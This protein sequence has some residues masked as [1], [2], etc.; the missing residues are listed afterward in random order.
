VLELLEAIHL[1]RDM[2]QR[3]RKIKKKIKQAI[4][5]RITMNQHNTVISALIHRIKVWSMGRR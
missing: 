3:D 4:L 1:I 2:D 5:V